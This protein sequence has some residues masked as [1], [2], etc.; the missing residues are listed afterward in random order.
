MGGRTV[1]RRAF[2]DLS[3]ARNT[4][5]SS[6]LKAALG[7]GLTGAGVLAYARYV[8]PYWLD[9]ERVTLELPRL[10]LPFDGYRVV[11]ISDIHMDGWMTAK[12]LDR[13]VDLVNKQGPDLVAITG[14]FVAVS[15]DYV[16]GISGPLKRLRTPDG[17]VA[18]LG[19]HDHMNDAAAVRRAL[20]WAG[21]SDVSNRVHTLCHD[22]SALHLCGVDSVME[23]LDDLDGVLETLEGRRPGCAVLLAHEPD[24]AD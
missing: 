19:N 7:S 21:V 6:Y 2:G 23:K 15:A 22:G 8:E 5:L 14:D 13:I 4:P 20:S 11:H 10:A 1:G 3:A 24:F 18:V 12:R 16:S 17:V 9:V